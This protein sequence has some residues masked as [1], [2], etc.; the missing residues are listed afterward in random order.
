MYHNIP[1]PVT[2]TGDTM[3]LAPAPTP[4]IQRHTLVTVGMLTVPG[5]DTPVISFILQLYLAVIQKMVAF[6]LAFVNKAVI[7]IIQN[8]LGINLYDENGNKMS[9]DKTDEKQSSWVSCKLNPSL[10]VPYDCK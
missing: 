5:M 4:W 1:A 8:V 3:T 10:N 2:L 9:N 7:E 6:S